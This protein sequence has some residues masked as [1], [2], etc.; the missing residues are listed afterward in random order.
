MTR[1][2]TVGLDGSP[3]SRAALQWAT[4]EALRR[5]LPLRLVHA[6][7]HPYGDTLV[8]DAARE[9]A[10]RHPRLPVTTDVADAPPA[11][12]LVAEAGRSEL[13][14]L[15]SQGLSGFTGFL[16]G[17]VGQATLARAEGPV[18]IVR[19]GL[20]QPAEDDR[21]PVVLGL[22]LRKGAD[23]VIAFAVD[24]AQ[25][26]GVPLRVVHAWSYPPTYGYVPAAMDPTCGAEISAAE[27]HAVR[28]ALVPW[29]ER[30]PGLEI[31]DA[32]AEGNAAQPLVEAAAGAS[33]LVVGRCMHR[34][35]GVGP[36]LGPVA[37]AVLHHAP[38]PVVVV[39][40]E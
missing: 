30:A 21:R 15:G 19:T 34:P 8:R 22:S 18:V 37:H 26:R 1:P 3:E 16:L 29:Q 4:Q 38:C 23:E 28:A 20:E 7:G 36:H 35:G 5:S 9:L 40:H 6:G 10:E 31:T 39:P 24:D 27:Q 13:L 32:V 14:A 11:E 2:V 25:R 12:L 17:T 33:L